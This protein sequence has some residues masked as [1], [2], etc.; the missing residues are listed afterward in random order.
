MHHSPIKD[1]QNEQ[2]DLEL[3]NKIEDNS[4]AE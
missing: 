4:T 3:S 1:G 2:R